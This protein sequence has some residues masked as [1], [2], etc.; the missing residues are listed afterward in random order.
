MCSARECALECALISCSLL[1]FQHLEHA[2]HRLFTYLFIW[3][4][5]REEEGQEDTTLS[6]EPSVGLNPL[7][8]RSCPELKQRVRSSTDWATQ[9]LQSIF[10]TLL[11][12][13]YPPCLFGP[14]NGFC[15]IIFNDNSTTTKAVLLL[16]FTFLVFVYMLRAGV[17]K[18]WS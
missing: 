17:L 12:L 7:T 18:V 11:N 10:N 14:I 1:L 15:R 5:S 3:R 2:N 9:V 16:H 13:T 6:A 8:P 4:S